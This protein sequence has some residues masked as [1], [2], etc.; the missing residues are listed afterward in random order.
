MNGEGKGWISVYRTILDWEWYDDANTFRL[1]MHCLLRA[2]HADK[3]WRGT[4]VKRGEFISSLD[5]LAGELRLSVKQIRTAISKLKRTNELATKGTTQHT[6][7]KVIN[8]DLY[9]QKDKPKGKQR[10]NEGQTRG[11]RRATN[12]NENNENNEN[13]YTNLAEKLGVDVGLIERIVKHRRD[14]NKPANTDKKISL[15]ISDFRRC[16]EQ[17][18]F[19]TLE[20]AMDKLDDTPWQTVKPNYLTNEGTNNV[21]SMN[22]RA[23]RFING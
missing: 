15:V 21:S 8:Y 23:A 5:K 14:I 19:Q 18:H 7:F 16:I 12:N 6:V 20:E 11:K 10:A 22:Q 3:E 9:Q 4:L 1:F 2:N 17:G 13:K